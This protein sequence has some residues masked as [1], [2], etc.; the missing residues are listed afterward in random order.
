MEENKEIKPQAIID[1]PDIG[2][3]KITGNFLLSDAKR[4]ILEK[5]SEVF[6]CSC[7]RS[8]NKPYCDGSHNK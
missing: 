5:P 8:G 1:V 7:G 2:P 6:L 3:I 4:D